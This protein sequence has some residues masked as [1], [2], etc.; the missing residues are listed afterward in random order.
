MRDRVSSWAVIDNDTL[1]KVFAM[2]P[3]NVK[4]GCESVCV[5]WRQALRHRPAAG[6]WNKS[7]FL[8]DTRQ[9][10]C[11][12]GPPSVFLD[13]APANSQLA[14]RITAVS[15]WLRQRGSGF[16]SVAFGRH[17]RG[18]QLD[19]PQKVDYF[20]QLV[21][22]L[23]QAHSPPAVHVHMKGGACAQAGRQLIIHI[24]NL[25]LP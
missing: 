20:Y 4:L 16:H 2:L 7:I 18:L 22:A 5:T 6:V 15:N 14:E 10:F 19:D 13:L 9:H 12:E 1:T 23:G 3:F 24:M 8:T 17:S 11:L 21:T 25:C